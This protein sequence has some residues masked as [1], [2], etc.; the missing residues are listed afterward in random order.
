[1]KKKVIKKKATKKVAKKVNKKKVA[2]K[3]TKKVTKKVTKKKVV[4]KAAKK[5][6]KKTAKKS[7]G[8]AALIVSP[9]AASSQASVS[10]FDV[11]AEAGPVAAEPEQ[12]ELPL[13]EDVESD[14]SDGWEELDEDDNDEG[15][16]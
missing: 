7:K 10:A 14:L 16:F 6:V 4:K 5:A 13:D 1:M 2:K 8:S 3:A 11:G 15:Y 9:E 12:L